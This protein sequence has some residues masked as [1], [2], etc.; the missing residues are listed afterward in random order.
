MFARFVRLPALMII[1][2]FCFCG[3]MALAQVVDPSVPPTG[4]EWQAF[5]E[6]L[7][8]AQGMSTLAL[9]ALG[10][11]G[12]MLMF[13]GPLSNLAGSGKILL[14]TGL[15]LAG[16]VVGLRASGMDWASCFMHSTTLAAV[17]VFLHQLWTQFGS[18]LKRA[19]GALK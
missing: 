2:M 7:G 5:F 3:T 10:V 1:S 4:A 13:R 8:G 19:N 12:L 15:T 11:Q 16:G 18:D 6:A 14:V 9:V 17:Q